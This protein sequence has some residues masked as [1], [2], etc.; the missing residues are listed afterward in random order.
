MNTRGYSIMHAALARIAEGHPD[1]GQVA[2]EA[3]A[4][5]KKV[6]PKPPLS[7]ENR[8]TEWLVGR[9]GQGAWEVRL[10]YRPE[11]SDWWVWPWKHPELGAA[12]QGDYEEVGRI[13]HEISDELHRADRDRRSH[14]AAMRRASAI[15]RRP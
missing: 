7:Y 10:E 9:I 12:H 14:E 1:P 6:P 2:R 15:Q 11:S 13:A 5:Q 8:Y 4:D 3:L